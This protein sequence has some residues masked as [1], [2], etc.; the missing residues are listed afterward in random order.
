MSQEEGGSMGWLKE[1]II[2]E[3]VKKAE[4]KKSKKGMVVP[5]KS[6]ISDSANQAKES[7]GGNQKE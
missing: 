2:K 1:A 4:P 7:L 5:A 3:S 6:G